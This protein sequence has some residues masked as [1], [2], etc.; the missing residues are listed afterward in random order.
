MAAGAATEY[1]APDERAGDLLEASVAAT[2]VGV[3]AALYLNIPATRWIWELCRAESG[4][5]WM[6]NSGVFDFEHDAPPVRTH[7]I[8][9]GIFATYPLWLR[10]G[11]ELAA[12]R[13][14]R[15]ASRQ[16]RE[17]A[18]PSSVGEVEAGH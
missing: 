8:A 7:A 4:R 14:S 16:W 10:L 18:Q 17:T 6:L 2:F 12:R 3:S 1:L 11:R 15:T 9:A 13:R 5:D